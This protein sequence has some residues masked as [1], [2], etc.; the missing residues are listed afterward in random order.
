[1]KTIT[2]TSILVRVLISLSTRTFFQPDEYFQALEPAH[3]AVFGYGDLTWEWCSENPIRS[4]IY[5]A[6]N[7]PVY[8]VLKVTGLHKFDALLIAGPKILHGIL[9]AGTDIGVAELAR[10]TL[11]SDYVETTALLSLT[12]FFHALA[13]SRSLSNSL[14]TTLSTLAFSYYPWDASS[15]LIPHVTYNPQRL[16]RA[17]LFSALA[18][19]IRPTNAVIW[20]FLYAKLLWSLR[21]YHRL[22]FT[23]FR[24][25]VVAGL[26][27]VLSLFVM[28]SLYYSR[29][30]STPYNFILTNFS[31]VS[32]FYGTNPWHYYLTQALPILCTTALP[33]VLHGVYI[34]IR[35]RNTPKRNVALEN[36]L[37]AVTWFIGVYSFAGH[38]EWRFIHPILPLLHIFAAKSLVDLGS[39]KQSKPKPT[40]KGLKKSDDLQPTSSNR[41]S[42]YLASLP[43]RKSHLTLLLLS[44]PVSF[45]IGLFYCDAPI[46]V[47]S[48][49]RSLPLPPPSASASEPFTDTIGFLM[50]C[51]STPGQSHIHRPTLAAVPGRLWSLGCEP[52]LNLTAAQALSYQDQTNVF[53]SDPRKYL[54]ERFPE[55][56]DALFPPSP[57]PRS[58]PVQAGVQEWRHEWPKHLIMFGE[59]LKDEYGVREVL[60]EKGYQEVWKAGREWE[61]E[62]TRKGGVRVWKW[63]E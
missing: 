2:S 29:L 39:S 26:T 25:L 51:H 53:Y 63:V 9:A 43:I 8:W 19:M 44:L 13:L 18:C 52:P 35:T 60:E 28:D 20:V 31:S 61:G 5:P 4:I 38:K 54:L 30:I 59:L 62:G 33:F 42:A 11:G 10:R 24:N 58:R 12:S 50:P 37:A 3:N 56:V 21:R 7:I 55:T 1:M 32:L 36:M 14:E 27:A 34:T 22:T 41:I 6:L 47:T 15:K 17:I 46:T 49:I 48:Y 16:G 57:F 40:K 45:Y 23:F